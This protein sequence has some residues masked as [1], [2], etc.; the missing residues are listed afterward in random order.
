MSDDPDDL[1]ICSHDAQVAA[2]VDLQKQLNEAKKELAFRSII[3]RIL[4]PAVK[5]TLPH[6]E[7]RQE[8]ESAIPTRDQEVAEYL[9]S[10]LG[11]R[12]LWIFQQRKKGLTNPQVIEAA[13]KNIC[14]SILGTVNHRSRHP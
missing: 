1:H 4:A 2:N 13:G 7:N 14:R 9:A 11:Q 10:S 12:D 8:G 3:E 5:A 6:P